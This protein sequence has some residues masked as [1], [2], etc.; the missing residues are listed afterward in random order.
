M[1]SAQWSA[2]A[3][4]LSLLLIGT[5]SW[6]M[7]FT[8]S[9]MGGDWQNHLWFLWEQISAMRANHTPSGFLST[10]GMAFYPEYFFYGGTLHVLA[11]ALAL[12][13]GN[14]T[15]A[16]YV[17]TYL[18]GFGAA[19]GG[20]YWMGRMAGLNRWL[21]H[22]PAVAFITSAC[23]LTL[24]YG[25]GDWPEFIAMSSIPLMLAAGLSVLSAQRLSRGLSW[26]WRRASWCFS[27]ATI[28]RCCGAPRS[29]HSP[30]C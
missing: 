9:S 26:R 3:I 5:L 11:G 20:W 30:A 4:A 10:P 18:G 22:A 17:L 6:P 12:I 14:S 2:L 15:T 19:Y 24:V 23:Y 28:S 25:Q 1:R 21:S 27:A 13:P 8:S 7:L 16:A 29:S